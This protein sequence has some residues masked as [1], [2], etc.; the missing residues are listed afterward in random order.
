MK[1]YQAENLIKYIKENYDDSDFIKVVM[2]VTQFK[3]EIEESFQFYSKHY[4]IGHIEAV[5]FETLARL[6]I[7]TYEAKGIVKCD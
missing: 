4:K 6:V 3:G 2:E 1:K 7:A 5:S